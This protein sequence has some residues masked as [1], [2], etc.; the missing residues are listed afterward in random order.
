MNEEKMQSCYTMIL[1]IL[2]VVA[3]VSAMAQSLSG[4]KPTARDIARRTMPSVALLVISTGESDRVNLGSGFFVSPDIVAT[5]FHVIEG[6][7]SGFAKIIGQETNY[8]I[9][10][11]VG[12]DPERDLALVKLKGTN[13]KPLPLG[14][15]NA[16]AIGDE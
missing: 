10:G 1:Y 5:N 12:L 11:F 15:S 3:P 7:T 8:Q 4:Q 14:D 13:A 2:L 9:L 6:A 16:I